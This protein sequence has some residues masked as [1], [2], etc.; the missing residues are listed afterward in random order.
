M[1]VP[2]FTPLLVLGSYIIIVWARPSCGRTDPL[3]Q[4]NQSVRPVKKGP[5]D[6]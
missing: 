6:D 1:K 5:T 2:H 4:Q 3:A